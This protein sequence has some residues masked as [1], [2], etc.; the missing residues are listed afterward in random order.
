MKIHSPELNSEAMSGKS[1]TDAAYAEMWDI[2]DQIDKIMPLNPTM[3]ME[4]LERKIT[5]GD[6][7]IGRMDTKGIDSDL[8]E[9]AIRLHKIIS[10]YDIPADDQIIMKRFADAAEEKVKEI[11][12]AEAQITHAS[13]SFARGYRQSLVG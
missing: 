3:G 1:L 12:T 6:E 5:S 9:L 7:K 11:R 13:G 2:A 10:T 4:G 8:Q